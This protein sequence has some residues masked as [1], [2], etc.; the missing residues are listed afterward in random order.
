VAEGDPGVIPMVAYADAPAAMDWL[1]DAF[2]FR[3]RRRM[4]DGDR[5]THGELDT[6]FG[7]IMLATG[8]AGY[9]GPKRHRVHCTA[10]DTWLSVPWIVDGVLVYVR[11]V[12][13]HH[14]HARRRGATILSAVESDFPGPRYR[15][16]DL[17][18]HRWMFMER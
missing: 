7:R 11:D 14:D 9:E 10:A 6:D 12:Q 8:P 1:C 16:E 18:G 4:M 5:L 15:A 3:E 13:A 17:E 2:G